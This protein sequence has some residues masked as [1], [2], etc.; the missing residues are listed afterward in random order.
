MARKLTEIP[1][2][3]GDAP[4]EI[5]G[6]LWSMGVTRDDAGWKIRVVN[7]SR[8][9]KDE[10]SCFEADIKACTCKREGCAC[11]LGPNS[12]ECRDKCHRWHAEKVLKL[13]NRIARSYS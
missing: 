3:P 7:A 13:A 12:G 11:D 5:T 6:Y 1:V 2:N 8:L 10:P 9:V 4:A